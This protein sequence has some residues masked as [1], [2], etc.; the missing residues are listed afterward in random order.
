MLPIDRVTTAPA[1]DGDLSDWGNL[2]EHGSVILQGLDDTPDYASHVGRDAAAFK[3]R[4]DDEALYIAIRVVDNSRVVQYPPYS[5]DCAQVF[6]DVRPLTGAGPHLGDPAITTGVIQIMVTAPLPGQ[7]ADHPEVTCNPPLLGPSTIAARSLRDGYTVEMRLPY[8]SLSAAGPPRFSDTI[9]IDVIVDD[10]DAIGNTGRHTPRTEY[11]WAGS[12]DDYENASVLRFARPNYPG[13][14]PAP[15]VRA[16]PGRLISTVG[17]RRIIG[18]VVARS[19]LHGPL[20]LT[21]TK[22]GDNTPLAGASLVETIDYPQLGVT[23]QRATLDLTSLEMSRYR[24]DTRYPTAGKGVTLAADTTVFETLS[25]RRAPAGASP[26]IAD[27]PDLPHTPGTTRL[28]NG[29][30]IA[31]VGHALPLPGDM[32]VRTIFT[33]DRRYLLVNTAGYHDQ[34]VNVIDLNTNRIVQSVDVGRNW[35]GM[36]LDPATSVLTLS[37]G[38]VKATKSASANEPIFAGALQRFA[39]KDGRLHRLPALDLPAGADSAACVGGI[40]TGRHGDLYVV[41]TPADTVSRLTG[42]PPTVQATVKVGYR[43][44]GIA[45]SPDGRQVAVSNWGGESVSLLDPNTLQPQAL[46]KVG[47]HPNDLVY[48]PDGRLYVANA[49]SNSVS[50]IRDAMVVETIKTS[51][52]P[53]APVGSTPDALTIAPDGKTLYIA[54]ADNNDVAVIDLSTPTESRVTGFIPTGWYPSALA[55]SPDG[56]RIYIGTAKGLTFRNSGKGQY[57]GDLLQGHISVV[58]TPDAKRLAAYTRQVVANLPTPD[59]TARRA[60]EGIAAL[61]KIKHVLYIIRENRTYDQVFGDLPEGNGDPG[62]TMFGREVTPNAHA[63]A[64]QTVLLDNLYC[65]GEVSE[66]GHQWC[67]AAYATDFTE[68]AWVNSYSDRGEPDADERLTASPAGYLWDNCARH[69]LTYY[70]YGEFA[71]FQSSP[72]SPPVFTGQ[73]TLAGHASEAWGHTIFD[74]HDTAKAQVFIDDLHA[75]EKTGDWPNFMVMSLGEDHTQGTTPGRYTPVAHVAA[76]DQALGEIVE[77][78]SRSKFWPETAIFVIEDDAQDGPDH[79][80]A[81]RTVGLVLSPYTRRHF[82][83]HTF[84]TTASFVRTMEMILNLPPMTQYDAAATPLTAAFSP[85]PDL[86]A[87]ARVP[88]RVNLE[89]RNGATG[90]GAALSAQLDFSGYDRVPAGI[91]NRI[92]WEALKPGVPQPAPVRSARIAIA[93]APRTIASTQN[94][95]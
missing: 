19:P 61:H 25:W 94:A 28:P 47:S 87:L 53:T 78:V 73:A 93:R 88:A 38:N 26:E 84:Y 52:E 63:L 69:G 35:T 55:V 95:N 59:R 3:L 74:Q 56:R 70:S 41:N 67:N 34:T 48:G 12:G 65:N 37:A 91:L 75:A 76:N 71:K 8:T 30:H 89:A 29:Q 43:P 64:Q 39:C 45:L 27:L 80:D 44:Y 17:D 40:A 13:W 85:Q 60:P 54:N 15:F 16:L 20:A 6:L 77:A 1:I 82:V 23:L 36:C 81:H 57:I 18:G 11:S 24:I 33:P 21:C 32:P 62:L 58:E 4:R 9:G 49:G 7:A 86:L 92:L 90:P 31:P 66:D 51:L 10:S 2:T 68:K 46:V 83:D 14:Y 79:V 72:T 50:V 5:G 22:E 42:A